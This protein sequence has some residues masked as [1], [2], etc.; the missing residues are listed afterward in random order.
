MLTF[1]PLSVRER[2]ERERAEQW[3]L[4]LKR[5]RKRNQRE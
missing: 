3:E 5:I 1:R 4:R 2:L